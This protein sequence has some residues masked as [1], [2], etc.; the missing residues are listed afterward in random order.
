MLARPVT[1]SFWSRLAGRYG[2][3]FYWQKE[4]QDT[5]IVNAVA[6]ASEGG[7]RCCARG[8]V[9]HVCACARLQSLSSGAPLSLLIPHPMP[10]HPH[11]SFA[12][13]DNCLREPMGRGQCSNIRGELE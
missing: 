4:G 12:A 13:I 3:K 1:Q 6:G 5:S 11:S 2:T 9:G 7:I 10:H 8:G